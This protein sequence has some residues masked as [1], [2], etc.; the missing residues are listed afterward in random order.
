L[1]LLGL[2]YSGQRLLEQAGQAGQA[3]KAVVCGFQGLRALADL[4]EEGRSDSL[5]R[6]FNDC[7]WK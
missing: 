2:L 6:L 1:R 3:G 7:D 5:A 4:I